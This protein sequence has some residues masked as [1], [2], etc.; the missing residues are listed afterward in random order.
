MG[1]I[2]LLVLVIG[3]QGPI[4][5]PGYARQPAEARPVLHYTLTI[6]SADLSGYLVSIRIEHAP[7]RFRLAMATHHEYDDRFWRF[8]TGFRVERP[9]SLH[10]VTPAN[11]VREDSAVWA[12][13]APGGEVIITY[14]IKLPPPAPVRFSHRPFLVSYGGLVGDLHSFMYLVEDPHAPCRLTL[15][16]YCPVRAPAAAATE[17]FLILQLLKPI[18]MRVEKGLIYTIIFVMFLLGVYEIKSGNVRDF[19]YYKN[20]TE[21]V[22]VTFPGDWLMIVAI[23]LFLVISHTFSK[24]KN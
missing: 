14:Y 5:T 21:T 15:R 9:A 6:D 10:P 22:Y 7:D 24:I 1:R 23:G 8:V 3:L 20:T 13:T 2:G 18:S 19:A 16:L 17:I 12:I 4:A 11:C